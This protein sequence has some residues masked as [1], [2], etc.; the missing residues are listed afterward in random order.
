MAQQ[1]RVIWRP[2]ARVAGVKP[3]EALAE[4]ERIA[5][6]SDDEL[7]P[8]A[9]VEA[10]RFASSPLHPLFEWSDTVAAREYRLQQARTIVRSVRIVYEERPDQPAFVWVPSLQDSRRGAYRTPEVLISLQDEWER[11]LRSLQVHLAS[12]QHAVND[13]KRIAAG[14]PNETRSEEIK[15]AV[16]ALEVA[17]SAIAALR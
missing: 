14:N 8:E 2:G 4:L 12:A 6:A 3:D 17:H 7:R 16:G 15:L 10:A 11:A 5:E 1:R 9:V 13:L